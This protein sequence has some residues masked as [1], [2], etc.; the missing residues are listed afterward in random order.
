MLAFVASGLFTLRLTRHSALWLP[1][2]RVGHRR[3]LGGHQGRQSVRP[4]ASWSAWD[5]VRPPSR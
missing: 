1:T 2:P 5:G 3:S 4:S